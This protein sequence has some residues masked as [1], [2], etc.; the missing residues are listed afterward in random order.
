MARCP[1]RLRNCN[2]TMTAKHVNELANMDLTLTE[3]SVPLVSRGARQ[4]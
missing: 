1:D 3:R 2:C 4:L